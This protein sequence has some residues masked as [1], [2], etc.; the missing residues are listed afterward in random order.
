[1]RKRLV[2]SGND[3]ESNPLANVIDGEIKFIDEALRSVAADREQIKLALEILA[4]YSYDVT[5]TGSTR[6][7]SVYITAFTS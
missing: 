2:R 5:P 1:M 7:S 4:D 3:Q 6:A